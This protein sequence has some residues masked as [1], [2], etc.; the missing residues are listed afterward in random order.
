MKKWARVGMT[1]EVDKNLWAQDQ[2]IA[3]MDAFS[4]NRARLDGETYF[5]EQAD[6]NDGNEDDLDLEGVVTIVGGSPSKNK[7]LHKSDVITKWAR[8]GMT[9]VVNDELWKESQSKAIANAFFTGNVAL[10]GDTYFPEEADENDG[11]E[12][13]MDLSGTIKFAENEKISVGCF[14]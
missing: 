1:F 8:V 14:K 2:E 10:D 9:I 7:T 11:T 6:E 12:D 3:V 13:D 4:D 5:P